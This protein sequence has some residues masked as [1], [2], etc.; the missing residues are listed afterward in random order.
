MGKAIMQRMRWPVS[1]GISSAAFGDPTD[2]PGLPVVAK[3]ALIG[4]VPPI[5]CMLGP[6][7]DEVDF[8]E[9]ITPRLG[10]FRPPRP[11][12]PLLF[13][14]PAAQYRHWAGTATVKPQQRQI[15]DYKASG[16]VIQAPCHIHRR[17]H[18]LHGFAAPPD[19]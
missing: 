17:G 7:R 19:Y 16:A 8:W 3:C 18:Y 6:V 15:S 2:K 14:L 12:P 13:P 11:L 9:E 1:G 4:R 5:V 10:S